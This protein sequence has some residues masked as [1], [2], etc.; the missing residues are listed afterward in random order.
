MTN[1]YSNLTADVMVLET[2][3]KNLV[4][5]PNDIKIDRE[6]NEMGVLISITVNAGDMG[7]VIGRGGGMANAIQVILTA[8]GMA[9]NMR[10]HVQFLEPDG[11]N[12][13]G[14]RKVVK[15]PSTTGSRFYNTNNSK[16]KDYDHSQNDEFV[17]N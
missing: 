1:N 11:S 15:K 17:L 4:T 7:L 6:I 9:H 16:G 8:I 10:V 13:Y 5:E 3:L 14:A 2:I 12:K